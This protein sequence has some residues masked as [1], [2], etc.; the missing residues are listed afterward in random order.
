MSSPENARL[1]GEYR[2]IQAIAEKP[3]VIRWLAEQTTVSRPALV[4]EL[5]TTEPA[6]RNAFLAD[7]KAKASVEHPLVASVYEAV[8][9]EDCCYYAHEYL[10]GPTLQDRLAAKGALR[11]LDFAHLIR[12]V[13]EAQIHLESA[14]IA[15]SPIQPRHIHRDDQ[16]LVRLDNLAIAGARAADQSA[17]DASALGT[18]LV[19]LVADSQPGS[20]RA[21]TLLD[22]MRGSE[23]QAPLSWEQIR[24]VAL[25]IESQLTQPLPTTPTVATRAIHEPSPRIPLI[26]IIV[27]GLALVV[28]VG[29]IFLR[30]SSRKKQRPPSK[31]AGTSILIPSGRYETNDGT[32]EVLPAFRVL[33]HEVTVSEY[34]E[35]LAALDRMS[36]DQRD[37][38]FDHEDQPA[39]KTS[40]LPDDWANLLAAAKKGDLWNGQNVSLESPV[41]GVDWWDASA[42]AEWRKGRLPTQEEWLAALRHE[43]PDSA[44]IPAASWLSAIGETPDRTPAGLIG[45]AGSVAEWTRRQSS[46]PSNPLG[47][48]KWVIMGGS[49]LRPGTN[50]MAREWVD[51]R[52]LRRP[53]LG[54]R[55]VFDAE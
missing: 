15:S 9:T 7:V 49:Y 6:F 52:S 2:L 29:A 33:A 8:S 17:Q 43:C 37:K 5:Q 31:F 24:D 14:R 1:L 35:F 44:R 50:A 19:P 16:G 53:D 30:P 51:E 36:K 26:W 27:A 40:H 11:P 22:W 46:D 42:Y 25:Q 28:L 47:T 54:F 3:N 12:R 10:P 20:T 45:M 23:T 21:F 39:G 34:A 18:A 41:V 38:V 48:R 32:H 13:A 4:D 55:L